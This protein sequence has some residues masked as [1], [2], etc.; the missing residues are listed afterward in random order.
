METENEFHTLKGYQLVEDE[1]ITPAME[2]YLEMFCRI[3][4]DKPRVRV[5]DIAEKLNV[6]PPSA[7]KMISQLCQLGYLSAEKY[8]EISLTEKGK[9]AGHY[10]LY[11]HSVIHSFLCFLNGSDNEL[12]EAEKIEHFL[13]RKTVKNMESL[14]MRLKRNP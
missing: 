7:S 6:R 3:F 1:E 13:S 5:R 14:L 2:D 9:A 4:K 11:R 8:G 10:L 12:E